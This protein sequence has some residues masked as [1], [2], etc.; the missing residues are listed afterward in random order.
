MTRESKPPLDVTVE[1]IITL[2]KDGVGEDKVEDKPTPAIGK[3]TDPVEKEVKKEGENGKITITNKVVV[4]GKVEM[5]TD[6][7]MVRHSCWSNTD[8]ISYP[9]SQELEVL[10]KTEKLNMLAQYS[11]IEIDRRMKRKRRE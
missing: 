8:I 5:V 7:A 3:P 9:L 1:N 11:T 10:R 4:P 6:E 2:N